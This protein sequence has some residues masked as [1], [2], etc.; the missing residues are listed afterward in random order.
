M[1]TTRTKTDTK[2]QEKRWHNQ[3]CGHVILCYVLSTKS[4]TNLWTAQKIGWNPHT[5]SP[6]KIFLLSFTL[7]PC[8]K[9][10]KRPAGLIPTGGESGIVQM[11]EAGWWCFLHTMSFQ[12]LSWIKQTYT[13]LNNMIS[14]FF[15]GFGLREHQEILWG[16]IFLAKCSK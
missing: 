15:S 3:K 14:R 5:P 8:D 1:S 2:E 13:W 7:S 4:S 6:V 9:W 11:Y 12:K 10:T 16:R